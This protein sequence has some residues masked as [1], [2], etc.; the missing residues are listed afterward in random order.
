MKMKPLMLLAVAVAC[1]L[2]A[3]VG[4]QQA[5]NNGKR[6]GDDPNLVKVF[7]AGDDIQA[8]IP[9]TQEMLVSRQV[10]KSALP[11]GAV[12]DLKQIEER[13]LKVKAF[14][15]DL[16]FD[17]KLCK[18][19]QAGASITIPEGMRAFTIPVTETQAHSGMVQ[20]NDRVDVACAYEIRSSNGPPLKKNRTILEYI[21]V[22]AVDNNRDLDKE[23][24]GQKQTVK[25]LTLLVTPKQCDLL[26]LMQSAGATNFNFSLRNPNDK[27]KVSEKKRSVD[28]TEIDTGAY[29][30]LRDLGMHEKPEVKKEK[31]KPTSLSDLDSFLKSNLSLLSAASTVTTKSPPAARV[32]APKKF[33]KLSI[34]DNKGEKI[35]EEIDLSPQS[36]E[37]LQWDSPVEKERNPTPVAPDADPANG[38]PLKQSASLENQYDRHHL[39]R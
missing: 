30:A 32:P 12:T 14:K 35:T 33:W 23:K 16:I 7:A 34:L 24:V 18:K 4:V 19:G 5:L 26:G 25:S 37:S 22:F 13:A 31:P 17:A 8:G 1:G 20:P 2:I 39:Y 6:G 28:F 15:G 21:Q 36:N 38:D 10:H 9:I 29:E 3:M 27:P 11:E